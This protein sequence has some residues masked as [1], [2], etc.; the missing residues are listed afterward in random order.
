[1]NPRPSVFY[2]TLQKWSHIT[3]WSFT[4]TDGVL[5]WHVY[6]WI[7][8][9]DLT[10]EDLHII[11]N[12]NNLPEENTQG[13]TEIEFQ[14]L[15]SHHIYQIYLY[16][17]LLVTTIIPILYIIVVTRYDLFVYRNLFIYSKFQCLDNPCTL[18]SKIKSDHLVKTQGKMNIK[19]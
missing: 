16:N 18:S 5:K 15:I 14:G 17:T 9:I 19:R 12:W 2:W 4:V 1:M 8:R 11:F 13:N 10:I 6:T 3:G 7:Y